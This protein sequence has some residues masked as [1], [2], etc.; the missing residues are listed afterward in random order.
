MKSK[1][2]S[3]LITKSDNIP[4]SK[5]SIEIKKDS[6]QPTVENQQNQLIITPPYDTAALATLYN[7]NA[8]H[9]R[10]CLVKAGV[11]VRLGFSLFDPDNAKR[12]EDKDY[13]RAKEFVETYTE[14]LHDFQVDHE[15]YGNCYLEVVRNGKGEVAEVYHIAAKDS[16]IKIEN[17]IRLLQELIGGTTIL[18]IPYLGDKYQ[19]DEKK[20]HEYIHLKNYNPESRYYGSPEYTGAISAMYL[21]QSAKT[22]NTNRFSNPV[23]ESIIKMF[24]F[25]KDADTETNIKNFFTNNMGNADKAGKK[26]LLLWSESPDENKIIVDKMEAD[27]RDASFRGM[28]QDNREEIISA[29]G[30]SPR[31]VG[32]ES[33]SKLGGGG[34]VREQLKLI[35]ELVFIPRKKQLARVVNTLFDGMGIKGWRIKFDNFEFTNATEDANFYS[36][37]V[38]AGIITPEYAAQEQGYPPEAVPGYQQEGTE[39][40]KQDK[41]AMLAKQLKAL[42]VTLEAMREE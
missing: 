12:Q 35:N 9:K 19:A 32:L 41:F 25:E 14:E 31:L 4:S 40:K 15:I 37:M 16:S 22:F 17:K 8:Y 10:C 6:A 26:V 21:D 33:I 20:R 23:P 5:P 13:T 24:G 39:I 28:R 30:L 1:I 42:R 2:Q 18:Y 3:T 38:T 7:M 36:T 34:E 27:I 11:T 29:H